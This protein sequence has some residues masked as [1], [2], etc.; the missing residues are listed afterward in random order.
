MF[1]SHDNKAKAAYDTES[2]I[3]LKVGTKVITTKE[4]SLD[5]GQID[6]L[7]RQIHQLRKHYRKVILVTSGAV[8]AGREVVGAVAREG[9][10]VPE[11]QRY[12]AAGAGPLLEAWSTG[13]KKAA[14]TEKK[15]LAEDPLVVYQLL[16]TRHNFASKIERKNIKGSIQKIFDADDGVVVMNENDP[17]SSAELKKENKKGTKFGDNDQLAGYISRLMGARVAVLLSDNGICVDPQL[18]DTLIKEIKN[19]SDE[20]RQYLQPAVAI[21]GRGG[22]PEKD[23]VAS[24]L[25]KRGI[26]VHIAAGREVNILLRILLDGEEGTST[27]YKP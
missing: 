14:E 7:T 19:G 11:Q 8:A 25:Q 4:G 1:M 12:A 15:E 24:D 3:V 9:E 10:S 20:H 22:A 2:V 18:P 27:H 21:N 16:L 26:P 5:R 17:V 13:F 6:K 23:K